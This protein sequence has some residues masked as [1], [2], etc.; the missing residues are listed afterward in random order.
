[1]VSSTTE[2]YHHVDPSY[3]LDLR[4]ER[5]AVSLHRQCHVGTSVCQSLCESLRGQ[6]DR[7]GRR[8]SG[9]QTRLS[10]QRRQCLEQF[11]CHDYTFT[12]EAHDAKTGA[13]IARAS[14]STDYR[15]VVTAIEVLPLDSAAS[16]ARGF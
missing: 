13:A 6:H 2:E 3:R 5:R 7:A 15:G 9:L 10:R 4:R 12:L 8:F 16:L 11:L 14:C 1:L